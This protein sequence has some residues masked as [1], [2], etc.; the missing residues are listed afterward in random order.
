[1]QNNRP[2]LV[3]I[4]G[5]IGSGKSIVCRIFQSM[6]IPIYE[7]D[8]RAKWLMSHDPNLKKAIQTTF[9]VDTY[10]P[11]GTLNRSYLAAQVFNDGDKVKQL[12]QL[13]HPKVGEDYLK[14]VI[15]FPKAPFLLNEAALMFEAG[16]HKRLDKVIV[17][18]APKPLRLARV[19]QR[20]PQRSLTEIEAIMNKQMP[21]EEKIK[22]ADFVIYNDNQHAVVPQVLEVFKRLEKS[23]SF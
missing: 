1:M 9:G 4:T 16:T 14:W 8:S 22:M 15:S 7:A 6:G 12:N 18:F 3:G 13:V 17:V 21:E 11:D 19:Q 5:G 20:D 2:L 23:T 10:L